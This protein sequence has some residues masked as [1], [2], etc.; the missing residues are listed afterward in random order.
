VGRRG[1]GKGSRGGSGG[2]LRGRMRERVQGRAGRGG[3]GG[4]RKQGSA[5]DVGDI[6][7]YAKRLSGS[8]GG[9]SALAGA[10]SGLAGGGL[11]SRFLGTGAQGSDEDFRA[12][13]VGQLSLMDERLERLEEQ[14]DQ[15]LGAIKGDPADST[16]PQDADASTN[17]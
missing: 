3:E 16:E 17:P 2:R 13:I 12:E 11:A 14:I 1:R 7:G 9:T 15:L 8:G 10:A 4:G 5:F 6:K